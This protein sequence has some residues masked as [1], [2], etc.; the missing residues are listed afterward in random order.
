LKFLLVYCEDHWSC[1]AL[2]KASWHATSRPRCASPINGKLA[3]TGDIMVTAP[4]LNPVL[5]ILTQNRFQ[6]LAVHNHMIDEHPRVFFIHFWK[7]AAPQDVS[8]GLKA[9]LAEA[10]ARP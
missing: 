5:S 1:A 8:S 3:T 10:R 4:E 9:A 2:T 7:I 6:I